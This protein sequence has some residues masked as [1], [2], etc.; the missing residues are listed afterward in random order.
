MH[1]E[2][3]ARLSW[4]T[5][6]NISLRNNGR[7]DQ[8]SYGPIACRIVLHFPLVHLVLSRLLLQ[9]LT[10]CEV[11]VLRL[12]DFVNIHAQEKTHALNFQLSQAR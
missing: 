5:R 12:K 1:I 8:P 10:Q 2:P 7:C 11:T 3:W 9:I 6:L 4:V